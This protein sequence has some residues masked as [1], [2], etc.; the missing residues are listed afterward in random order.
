MLC[1]LMSSSC[2]A[3]L[4]AIPTPKLLLQVLRRALL[5]GVVLVVLAVVLVVQLL[6]AL[7]RLVLGALAVDVVGALGLAELVDLAARDACQHLFG[8]LVVDG[9]AW[10]ER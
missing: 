7:A 8:E 2:L 4:P 10:K 6:G 9:L 1:G 3:D 5:V